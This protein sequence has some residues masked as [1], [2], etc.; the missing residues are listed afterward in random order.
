[1]PASRN[2]RWIVIVPAVL[3]AALGAALSPAGASVRRWI[4]TALGIRNSSPAL[5]KLPAPG[6]VLVTGASG[7]WT[8]AA[9]GSIRHVGPWPTASWSPHGEYLSATNGDALIALDPHGNL[10]WRLARPRVSGATWYPPLGYRVAYLSGRQLRVVVGNGTG[11]HVLAAQV[12]PVAPA[13]RP[14]HAY[15]LTYLS[16]SGR[17][18]TRDA[19]TGAPTLWSRRAPAGTRSLAWSSNGSRLLVLASRGARVYDATGRVVISAPSSADA[20]IVNA[21]LSPDGR[22]LALVRGGRADDAVVLGPRGSLQRVVSGAGLDQVDWS[23][24]GHWL[25]VSWPR[26]NQWVF[27]RVVGSPPRIQAVSRISQQFAARGAGPGFPTLAG[28]CCTAS[29]AAG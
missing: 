6:S 26:A 3:L 17:L 21:A 1:V 13:W 19:D 9:D 10:R 20:P 24:D 8:V 4:N 28:W 25:L 14:G 5:F 27:D 11:D 18:E 15:D 23:P 29:G 7:T 2:G 22:R 12:T 16:A